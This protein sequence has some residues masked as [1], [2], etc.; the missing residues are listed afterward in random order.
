MPEIRIRVNGKTAEAEDRP[1]IVCGNSDYLIRFIFDAEW[2][3]YAVKTARFVFF[4]H[5]RLFHEDVL[6]EGNICAAPVL[7]ET[8]STAVGVYAGDIRTTTPARIPCA[9]CITDSDSVH[10]DPLPDVYAQIL[11]YLADMEYAGIIIGD[12]VLHTDG[13]D[14]FAADLATEWEAV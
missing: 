1:V 4:R 13:T 2:D 12:A 5:G 14:R 7:Y 11:A 9:R 6:F 3:A 10:P 8:D